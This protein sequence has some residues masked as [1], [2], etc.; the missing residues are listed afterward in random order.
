MNCA[1]TD[2]PRDGFAR[3]RVPNYTVFDWILFNTETD[4]T[5]MVRMSVDAFRRSVGQ[6]GLDDHL[7]FMR[8]AQSY[9]LVDRNL[10]DNGC[11]EDRKY[12]FWADACDDLNSV[13]DMLVKFKNHNADFIACYSAASE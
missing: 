7:V 8:V 5:A 11:T 4:D 13:Q 6:N 9:R 2:S 3:M 12:W 10:Q 1:Y